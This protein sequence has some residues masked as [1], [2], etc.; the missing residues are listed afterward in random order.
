MST[1]NFFKAFPIRAQNLSHPAAY[2]A[3]KDFDKQDIKTLCRFEWVISKKASYFHH[4]FAPLTG[5]NNR[6]S[7]RREE[8]EMIWSREFISKPVWQ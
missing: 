6:E 3:M 5:A 4:P 2:V 7:Q 8:T 1:F